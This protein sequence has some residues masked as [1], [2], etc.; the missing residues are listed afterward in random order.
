MNRPSIYLLLLGVL[1]AAAAFG[2][3]PRSGDVAPLPPFHRQFIPEGDIQKRDW[4]SRYLP[5]DAS[6]FERDLKLVADHQRGAPSER[7]PR[8]QAAEYNA[9]LIG[10]DLLVGT[11]RFEISGSVQPPT[12]LTFG[13]CSVAIESAR[14]PEPDKPAT[15]AFNAAGDLQ[16]LVEAAQLELRWSQRGQRTA[17]GA[18]QFELNLPACI[19]GRFELSIAEGAELVVDG[20][21][22]TRM[23]SAAGEEANSQRGNRWMIELSG[24]APLRVRVVP[25]ESAGQRRPLT[26][27]RQA[28]TYE[29][30]TRGINVAT[31]LRLDIHGEPLARLEVDLDPTL[32]LI[33]AKSGETAIPW[34]SATDVDTGSTHVILEFPEPISGTGRVIQ[35]ASVMPLTFG[36]SFLLPRVRPR[37]VAW[38]EGTATLLI[39][40]GL[41]LEQL[42]TTGCRQSRVTALPS[43]LTGESIEVQFY[44][45][46]GTIET[47][48]A[49]LRQQFGLHCAHQI[50]VTSDAIKATSIF[51]L[52]GGTGASQVFELPLRAGWIVDSVQGVDSGEL[53]PWD[54]ESTEPGGAIRIHPG[55]TQ[56]ILIRAHAPVASEQILLAARLRPFEL[57]TFDVRIELLSVQGAE[58]LDVRWQGESP[59]PRDL[60]SLTPEQLKLFTRPPQAAVFVAEELADDAVLSV[61]PER[62]EYSAN[63]HVDVVVQNRSLTETVTILCTPA[64]SRVDRLLVQLSGRRSEALKWSL[65]GGNNSGDFSARRLSAGEQSKLGLPEGEVWE[66]VLKLTRPGTFEVRGQR[67]LP[68][69]Q[70]VSVVLARVHGAVDQRGSLAIRALGETGLTIHNQGL[71]S[72]PTEVLDDSRYQTARAAF[73]YQPE[74]E[75]FA[76][77]NV[78]TL[79]P[80]APGQASTGAWAWSLQVMS[81]LTAEGIM[82]HEATADLQTAGRRQISFALPE[83]AELHGVWIDSNAVPVADASRGKAIQVEL[84]PGK[85]RSQLVIRYT[86]PANLPAVAGNFAPLAP[87]LDV[88]LIH[89]QW[90]LWLP[91]GFEAGDPVSWVPP[92]QLAPLTWSQRLFG[93]LGRNADQNLFNPLV[94]DDWRDHL[95]DPA[96]RARGDG[97]QRL[98]N[99]MAGFLAEYKDAEELTW[100]Q[101]LASIAEASEQAGG[102]L[103]VDS[104]AF[105]ELGMTPLTRLHLADDAASANSLLRLLQDAQLVLISAPGRLLITNAARAAGI[106]SRLLA[107]HDEIVLDARGALRDELLLPSESGGTFVSAM[108]WLSGAEPTPAATA[109]RPDNWAPSG[110]RRY[111]IPYPQGTTGEVRVVHVSRMRSLAWAMLL[112]MAGL[113]LWRRFVPGHLLFGLLGGVA[114]VA[115]LVPT[116]IAPLAT[117][118]F[119]GVLFGLLGRLAAFDRPVAGPQDPLA[120]RGSASKIVRG[121]TTLLLSGAILNF[122]L[123]S[124]IAQPPPSEAAGPPLYSVLVPVDDEHHPSSEKIY[125]PEPLYAS[126]LRASAIA[127]G[128]PEGWMIARATYDGTLSRDATTMGLT[129]SGLRARYELSVYQSN[130]PI[131][132]P[133]AREPWARAVFGARLDG[134]TLRLDWQDDQGVLIGTLP[135]GTHVLDFDLRPNSLNDARAAGVDLPIPRVAQAIVNL[136]APQDLETIKVLSA[137]G[138]V[139]LDAQRDSLVAQ[140]GA[141]DRLAIRWPSTQVDDGSAAVPNLLVD[142]LVWVRVRPG[143][144]VLD[145]RFKFQVGSGEL[146]SVRLTT[147]P[148]LRLLNAPD[149]G[150]PIGAVHTFPG[151]PQIVEFELAR[152][153]RDNVTLDLSFLVTDAS[154]VGNLRLP[155][156]ESSDVRAAKRW[157][158]VSVDPALQ[159]RIQA[160]EDSPAVDISKFLEAWGI[161]E[162]KP[163]AAFSIPRGE[164]IWFLATQPAEPKTAVQ[165]KTILGIGRHTAQV[166]YEASLDVSSGT[167]IQLAV[168]APPHFKVET[169]SVRDQDVERV[170]RWSTNENGPI[171][172]FLS[173][174][175]AGRQ[176]LVLTGRWTLPETRAFDVPR[177]SLRAATVTRSE[178]VFCRQNDVLL[179]VT[180]PPDARPIEPINEPPG[181]E[182]GA[183][184]QAFGAENADSLF[185]LQVADNKPHVRGVAVSSIRRDEDQWLSTI[186]Y[187][188]EISEGVLDVL[189]FEVPA[190]F[191]EPYRVEAASIALRPSASTPQRRVLSVTPTKPLSGKQHLRIQGR[192]AP[193]PGDRVRIPAVKLLGADQLDWFVLLPKRLDSQPVAWETSRLVSERLPAELL[194]RGW[195]PDSIS[196]FKV[197][198]ENFQA[199]L[200]TVERMDATPVIQLADVHLALMPGGDWRAVALFDI[201]PGGATEC[202]LQLPDQCEL[203][204]ATVERLPASLVPVGEGKHRIALGPQRLP[205]RVT[206]LYQSL[207]GAPRYAQA[208]EPPRLAGTTPIQTLWTIYHPAE[209]RV[210]PFELRWSLPRS[211]QELVR[212]TNIARLSD[213]PADVTGDHLPDEI[214]RWYANWRHRYAA[215]RGRLQDALLAAGR[216]PQSSEEAGEARGLDQKMLALDD[217][218]GRGV[219]PVRPTV[220]NGDLRSSFARTAGAGMVC[221]HYSLKAADGLLKIRSA[222]DTRGTQWHWLGAAGAIAI[223]GICG[224]HMRGRELPRISPLV[225]A[226]GVAA[227]WWLVLGPSVWGLLV[228]TLMLLA[229]LWNQGRQRPPAHS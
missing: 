56:R 137:K 121:V 100:G 113:C 129:L 203:V 118:A 57:S 5:V 35:L 112:G 77:E 167:L 17:S 119:L 132:F 90:Q 138:R 143:T 159:F 47:R 156:L 160:G 2:A 178:W 9:Q 146:R 188:L 220:M 54:A 81:R 59:E 93:N 175:I 134:K 102:L 65:A 196:S 216:D 3:P 211:D 152:P 176:Q 49:E 142:E 86:T 210:T 190:Q 150:S 206:L 36:T 225:L 60:A 145:A 89:R 177:W 94:A 217:R 164:P 42:Q 110:W 25:R 103:L 212:L 34:S 166:R 50:E 99:Q 95:A 207:V 104:A 41:V 32:H 135:T 227:G 224:W 24:A 123:T 46:N 8:L 6:E 139:T 4:K 165:Q 69:T 38:Q 149:S 204:N 68:F 20:G 106:D 120:A 181:S 133:I 78:V 223:G 128:R 170:T 218:F 7:L 228:L 67:T 222:R 61:E 183:L 205:Q 144:T 108:S 114:A 101:L 44:Q 202:E 53:L 140:L 80:T 58:G 195:N 63:V 91:P 10:E 12:L 11:A 29:V 28:A 168:D 83:A 14:W 192:I 124:G 43:P 136:S 213:L 1:G 96:K 229:L 21:I 157:L 19:V 122:A 64:T 125:V 179:T 74:P 131:Y 71:V 173:A 126:L 208:F 162:A 30:S 51:E 154:G 87:T 117:A 209:L 151:S 200:K 75:E 15:V 199:S 215:D 127:S 221:E 185:Q 55:M 111:D 153:T 193:L 171:S 169:V 219:S 48:I 191:V 22:A 184:A 155:R 115:L 201:L 13:P 141:A 147:D 180:S 105:D 66:L 76:V 116:T 107:R 16:L 214:A 37:Q 158:G 31:Q 161:G 189:Q 163:L 88:P 40:G 109:V 79:V 98:I 45:S 130:V 62:P 182:F 27:L 198:D 186:D 84:P 52:A 70:E 23:L 33:T 73:H 172:I 187:H 39:P 26:L 97:V 92:L 85:S 194:P 82:I 197:Q 72:A 148:R 174:P 226:A 18:V